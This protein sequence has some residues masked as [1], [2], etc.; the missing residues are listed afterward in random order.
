MAPKFWLRL[1]RQGVEQMTL[2]GNLDF[3]P[4]DEVLRLLTRAGN[5][6]ALE[7]TSANVS[8]RVFVTGK[9]IGLATTLSDGSLREHLI[10]SGYI[11]ASDLAA[12]EAGQGPISAHQDDGE[13]VALI[14]EMTVESLHKMETKGA[15]FE[16]VKDAVSPYAAAVPF[17]LETII[18]D[19]RERA[20]QWEEVRRTVSDLGA[21]LTMNR[22]LENDSVELD[23]EAWRL[24]SEIGS[25]ASV[26]ELANRLGTTDFAIARVA[27]AMAERGLLN[28]DGPAPG[29]AAAYEQPVADFD[30]DA[31]AEAAVSSAPAPDPQESWWEEPEIET[32]AAPTADEHIAEE[33]HAE[34]NDFEGGTEPEPMPESQEP[35]QPVSSDEPAPSGPAP[36]GEEDADAF[37]EKVFSELGPGEE[38][39]TEGHGLMRRRRMG[40]ILRELGED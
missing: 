23:R 2:S 25:G 39:E 6:S 18:R 4:L 30:F 20:V 21:P 35:A 28:V 12:I 19:S 34:D 16:V 38:E 8:G 17:D 26:A 10:S 11:S 13:L 15:D 1:L 22:D 24:I 37:L 29:Q 7:I 36:D 40:S 32:S 31:V 14:R 5:D 3:V 9:G 33:P 27:S